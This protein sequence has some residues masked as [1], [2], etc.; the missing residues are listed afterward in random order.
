MNSYKISVRIPEVDYFWL[1][2]MANDEKCSVSDIIRQAI[3]SVIENDA[4][5][6]TGG[7]IKNEKN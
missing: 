4:A 3:Y 5:K 7:I 6:I 1:R 2:R